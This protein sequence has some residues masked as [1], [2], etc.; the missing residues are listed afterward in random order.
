MAS[1]EIMLLAVQVYVTAGGRK[2]LTGAAAHTAYERDK[3]AAGSS[4]KD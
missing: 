1:K 2:Q 4:A 3:R